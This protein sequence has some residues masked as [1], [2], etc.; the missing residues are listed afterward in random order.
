MKGDKIY[1]CGGFKY[2]LMSPY[3]VQTDIL[4]DADIVTEYVL[5]GITGML[6]ILEGFAW[7]GPSGPSI[8]TPDF[9]RGSLVHDAIYF[10]IR[11]GKL[12]IRWRKNADIMLRLICLEDGMLN[13]RA[14]TVYQGVR[15]F[16][17]PYAEREKFRPIITAP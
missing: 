16:G 14:Q 6:S 11:T 12:D 7:D 17:D 8:D 4:P 15:I 13:L 5:L 2:Q 1:F 9:M 3:R 10:L